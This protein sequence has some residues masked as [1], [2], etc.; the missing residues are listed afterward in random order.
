M[1][2]RHTRISRAW[3]RPGCRGDCN[4]TGRTLLVGLLLFAWLAATPAAP[5]SAAT[6]S[7]TSPTTSDVE[8]APEYLRAPVTLDG[9]VL[10]YVRGISSYPATRRA[11]ETSEKIRN[12]AADPS[13]SPD[14]GRVPGLCG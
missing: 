5:A 10:F 3:Q 9:R 2:K 13:I 7:G 14:S 1:G 4:G 12:I 8:T 6:D 11:R